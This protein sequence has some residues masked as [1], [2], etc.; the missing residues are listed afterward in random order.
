[1]ILM[2]ALFSLATVY[3]AV[4][5][6]GITPPGT[7]VLVFN[8]LILSLLFAGVVMLIWRLY[9]GTPFRSFVFLGAC[10]ALLVFELALVIRLLPLGYIVSGFLLA[11]IVYIIQLLARFHLTDKG[12]IWKEQRLFL[13]LNAVL[14]IIFFLFYVRWV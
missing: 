13:I 6:L 14:F 1:M 8:T 9:Q 12:I 5:I 11:W 10:I 4:G 7:A 3:F 2:F